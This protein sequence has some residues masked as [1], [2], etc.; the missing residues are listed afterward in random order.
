MAGAAFVNDDELLVYPVCH[1]NVALSLRDRFQQTDPY[2]LKAVIV[3]ISTSV[4][5]RRFDLPTH[6]H[7]SGILVTL[8]GNLLIH[9]DNT[10]DLLDPE[11]KPLAG[12]QINRT[13]LYDMIFVKPSPT[14]HIVSLIDFPDAFEA[15]PNGVAVLDSRNLHALHQ[16][17]DDADMWNI[18][19]SE[20]TTVRTASRGLLLVMRNFND[21]KWDTVLTEPEP[22][23]LCPIF[24]ADSEFAVPL[25]AH[26][27]VLIFKTSGEMAASLK[28]QSPMTL[29]V[30]RG[31]HV[32]SAVWGSIQGFNQTN[33][34]PQFGEA[35]VNLYDIPS[36]R[37]IE[38]IQL[39][40]TPAFGAVA[41]SPDCT[42][43]AILDELNVS[44]LEVPPEPPKP[45]P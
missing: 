40:P 23:L 17:H 21:S 31:G 28:V 41:L 1:V 29:D 44:I 14:T 6:G 11:G 34:H 8:E 22:A 42:R 38:S 20:T 30:S 26:N 24:L 35:G 10:L 33:G 15:K 2:H 7:G 32:L 4:I 37:E 27:A 18:A 12:L 25:T 19:S 43:L 39:H 5:K 13:G 16:W 45:N 3:E 9:R 36:L